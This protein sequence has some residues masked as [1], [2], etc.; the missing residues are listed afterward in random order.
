MT[1]AGSCLSRNR[2]CTGALYL[3]ES[4]AVL[5]EGSSGDVFEALADVRQVLR[6]QDLVLMMVDQRQSHTE[7]DLRSLVEQTVPDPQNRLR[8]THR[9]GF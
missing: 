6:L 5:H 9:S 2:K 8:H 4:V 7:Q 3:H 1:S